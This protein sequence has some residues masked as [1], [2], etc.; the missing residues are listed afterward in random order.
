M[1]T[2]ETTAIA[3]D[4]QRPL[5]G[6]GST[7]WLNRSLLARMLDVLACARE[8]ACII[9]LS[10]GSRRLVGRE[11]TTPTRLRLIHARTH[12]RLFPERRNRLRRG[13]RNV[14]AEAARAGPYAYQRHPLSAPP[15]RAR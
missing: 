1:P 14:E 15:T 6:S 10:N 4:D 11:S 8:G 13:L 3:A 7:G 2:A 5:P 12:R 9:E